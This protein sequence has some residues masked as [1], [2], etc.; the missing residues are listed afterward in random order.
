MYTALLA[1]N[2]LV[3]IIVYAF[4]VNDNYG[5]AAIVGIS[6]IVGNVIVLVPRFYPLKWMVVGIILTILMFIYPLIFTVQTAFTNYSDGHLFTKPQSINLIENRGFV[7]EGSITYG[8][9]P[10]M[11]DAGDYA[12]WLTDT[13]GNV[14]FALPGEPLI[15]VRAADYQLKDFD[16]E[17]VP[18]IE[19]YSVVQSSDDLDIA[20]LHFNEP[21]DELYAGDVDRENRYL[22]DPV[23]GLMFDNRL[24]I[25]LEVLTYQAA[26]ADSSEAY[27]FWIVDPNNPVSAWWV[28]SGS[29]PVEVDLTDA[30]A[31]ADLGIVLT[32]NQFAP[33]SIEGYTF[34]GGEALDASVL[35]EAL[36]GIEDGVRIGEYNKTQNFIFD[37]EE[38]LVQDRSAGIFYEATFL[39]SEDGSQYILWLDGGRRGTLFARPDGVVIADGRPAEFNGYRQLID[40]REQTEALRYF[41]TIDFDYFGTGDDTVGIINTRSA[42]RPYQKRYAYDEEQDVI[43]DKMDGSIYRADN[44]KGVFVPKNGPQSDALQPGYRVNVGLYNF[45]RL[46]SDPALSGPLVTVFIWT[47]TFALLSVFTTF[48]MGLFM[49]LILDD[50]RIYGKKIIRSLLIIP[51]AIPGVIG[52][53]VW[54]GMLKQNVGI[55]TTSIASLTGVTIPWFIDP[56]WAKFAVIMVNLWLGY[57]YMMLV[58]SGALQAIP[59]DIYEAAA[60]DGAKASQRFWKITL[61]L[62]LVTV[63]PLLIASF[64]YNFNNYLIIEA[65]TQGNPPIPGTPIPVGYTDI[66]ISYTYNTAFGSDRGADYGYASAITIVIFAIVASVTLLQ[67]RSTKGWEETGEN[68]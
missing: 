3:L 10:Y 9:V 21:L 30:D 33:D 65:L 42:G 11:N 60:V 51:Y 31:L 41:Q 24:G 25:V 1:L 20:T 53:V 61:P 46:V 6:A 68:V 19:G 59:S 14:F 56:F 38:S 27:A 8:W 13:A 47:I 35:T 54:Q 7:P 63:G 23:Q 67:F 37:A 2:T 49:A 50:S 26:D 32:E 57:P 18:V 55:I 28:E 39:V 64:T 40:R 58:C 45:E 29:D 44:E 5:F 17:G 16:E 12:L 34:Y 52:L 62:L 22:Y 4:A 48:V 15:E 43:V 66:L 36:I